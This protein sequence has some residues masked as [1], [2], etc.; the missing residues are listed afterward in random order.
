MGIIVYVKK[1]WKPFV[2]NNTTGSKPTGIA[3][4]GGNKGG[5]TVSFKIHRTRFVFLNCHLAAG[6]SQ[7]KMKYR[8]AN[9]F[10]IL[11]SIRPYG[12]EIDM[13]SGSDYFFW[14]GDFNFR[15]DGNYN[16]PK[17]P[18]LLSRCGQMV[19][20]GCRGERIVQ[21]DFEI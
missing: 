13:I 15:T 5:I 16:T 21:A 11:Q 14:V 19:R 10:Q 1:R 17:N 4:I 6:A 20:P 9:A 2:T 3:G 7:E 12:S 8:R 18:S